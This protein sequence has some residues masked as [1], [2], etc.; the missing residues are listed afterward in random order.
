MVSKDSPELQRK[1]ANSRN[2]R[3]SL[4]S[5]GGGEYI[6]EQSVLA[7]QSNMPGVVLYIREGEKIYRKNSSV[8]GPG[9]EYCPQW[10]LLS[11]AGVGPGEWTPQFNY[12]K[13]A[14]VMDDGG[15]NLE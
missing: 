5:H 9:D 12:W 13:R 14:E 1:F 7:G 11:L 8:F 2:W 15:E 4:A 3:F 10:N 6:E